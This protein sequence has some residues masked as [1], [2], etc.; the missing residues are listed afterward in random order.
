MPFG[1]SHVSLR[2]LEKSRK[3]AIFFCKFL[4]ES[5]WQPTIREWKSCSPL[6]VETI[7]GFKIPITWKTKVLEPF[8]WDMFWLFWKKPKKGNFVLQFSPWKKH[9]QKKQC[10]PWRR[11]RK[12]EEDGSLHFFH[13]PPE[14]GLILHRSC[15]IYDGGRLPEIV[16]LS[17]FQFPWEMQNL[18][19]WEGK[20]RSRTSSNIK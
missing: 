18:W 7:T 3:N 4:H 12:N 17:L 14:S 13:R 1:V 2:S 10:T 19:L 8:P 5:K 16:I 9:R 6:S 11:A 15:V 20:G